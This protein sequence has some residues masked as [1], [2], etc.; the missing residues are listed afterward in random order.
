MVAFGAVG[1]TAA[2]TG[3]TGAAGVAGPT[4]VLVV[5]AGVG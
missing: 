2:F 5:E 1:I 4:E 3:V